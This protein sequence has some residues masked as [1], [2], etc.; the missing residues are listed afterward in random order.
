LVDKN[1]SLRLFEKDNGECINPAPGTCIDTG[2]VNNQGEERF[3]FYMIPHKATIATARPVHYD[4]VYNNTGVN[5]KKIEELTYHLC[6][7]YVNYQGS[8]KV[9]AAT[10][11]AQKIANYAL[12]NKVT[13][14]DSL[15]LNLHYL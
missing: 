4:I 2:L 12:E 14:S 5:K 1:S 9:P 15:E 7:S 3:D 6:Y 13:P 8:I 10:M 11:Y